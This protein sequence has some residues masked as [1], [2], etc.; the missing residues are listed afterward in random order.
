MNKFSFMGAIMLSAVAFCSCENPNFM[1]DDEDVPTT[2]PSTNGKAVKV[3]LRSASTAPIEYP[4]RIYAFDENNICRGSAIIADEA[5][6]TTTMKLPKGVY[7]MTAVSLPDAYPFADSGISPSSILQMPEGGHALSPFSTGNADITVSSSASQSVSIRMGYRQAAVNVALLNTPANVTGMDISLSSPYRTMSIGG[8]YGDAKS[9]TVP[10]VRSGDA[11]DT[12]TFYIMPTQQSQTVLTMHLTLADGS[13]ESYSYTYNAALDAGTPYVFTGKYDSVESSADISASIQG[14]EWGAPVAA[15]FC[16]GPGADEDTEKNSTTW[17][18]ASLPKA[19]DVV[20]GHVVIA[21]SGT[22]SAEAELL[23]VSLDEWSNV[24]SI[25]NE[26]KAA[27]TTS[28]VNNYSEDGL[29]EWRIPTEAEARLL[30]DMYSD[31]ASLASINTIIANAGG[32]KLA[33]KKSNGDNLRYLCGEGRS[34]FTFAINGN[35][36][37]AGRTVTY[38]MRLVKSIKAMLK[39]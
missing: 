33:K 12:G 28:I 4:V 10:C 16:F 25:E 31:D 9:V 32:V 34:T 20:N 37:S 15:D 21:S 14:G 6:N 7:R 5:E 29:R 11:W 30:H 22:S 2:N 35:I 3:S 38:N 24:Y 19:G 18:V 8:S 39:Q 26:E 23:L 1:L 36:N 13:S 27:E 17:Y